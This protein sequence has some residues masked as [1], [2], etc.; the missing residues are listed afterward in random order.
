MTGNKK[1]RKN[2]G[3]TPL[4]RQT[5]RGAVGSSFFVETYK[6]NGTD[7]AFQVK[8]TLDLTQSPVVLKRINGSQVGGGGM[9]GI[10]CEDS[11]PYA[12]S[13]GGY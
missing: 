13:F 3:I 5:K 6:Q 4:T 1:A 2:S 11:G 9:V 7:I 10:A 8:F 12:I